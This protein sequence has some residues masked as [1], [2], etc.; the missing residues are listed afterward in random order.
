MSQRM[1]HE[2]A[3]SNE[4]AYLRSTDGVES[5]SGGKGSPDIDIV[6][7]LRDGKTNT[8]GAACITDPN[9]G[10]IHCGP[11]VGTPANRP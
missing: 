1:S 11:I 7:L 9:D 8:R 2:N 5:G 4:K 3:A 6:K 10:Y